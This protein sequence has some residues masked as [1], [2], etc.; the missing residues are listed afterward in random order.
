[1]LSLFR[2]GC[3][4]RVP[5]T[6]WEPSVLPKGRRRGS[7]CGPYFF[8]TFQCVGAMCRR[9]LSHGSKWGQTPSHSGLSQISGTM[10]EPSRPQVIE[11]HDSSVTFFQIIYFYSK[12]LQGCIHLVPVIWQILSWS[13]V[14]LVL[15]PSLVAWLCPSCALRRWREPRWLYL[16]VCLFL[17][18][19]HW[20]VFPQL[21]VLLAR[22]SSF[23]LRHRPSNRLASA[24]PPQVAQC[25][26]WLFATC[27]GRRVN[28][29]RV[30]V[31]REREDIGR[32]WSA[33]TCGCTA[34]C[35][36]HSQVTQSQETHYCCQT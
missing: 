7:P 1:M 29:K 19:C 34:G 35:L 10:L 18:P 12:T 22:S 6:H 20:V 31:E 2:L 27:W 24:S 32:W 3:R 23:D 4:A 36:C 17:L 28:I 26:Q 16:P 15:R 8:G 5:P 14:G 21:C 11:N 13:I 33:F 30:K 9:T 25:F